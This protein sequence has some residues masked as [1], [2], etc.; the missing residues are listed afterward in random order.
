MAGEDAGATTNPLY[1][2]TLDTRGVI[3]YTVET[4][5]DGVGFAS[6][7][8]RGVFSVKK[9]FRVIQGLELTTSGL[10]PLTRCDASGMSANSGNM[11]GSE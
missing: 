9:V 4:A 6:T 2:K 8:G 10:R 5:Q 11:P 7:S 3:Q 1:R